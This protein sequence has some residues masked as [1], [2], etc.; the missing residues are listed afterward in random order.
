MEWI[1][2][3]TLNLF[4]P[5]HV[6]EPKTVEALAARWLSL[7]EA[8]A[9]AGFAHGDL[10]H[11]NILVHSDGLKLIDY[12]GLFVPALSGRPPDEVGHRNYQPP[13][14]QRSDF[15]PEM[16]RFSALLILTALYSL[17][18][19]PW[20]WEKHGNEENLLFSATDLAAPKKS[21]LFKVLEGSPNARLRDLSSSLSRATS[22]NVDHPT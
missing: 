6:T 15:G 8:M 9:K 5:N 13:W 4:L 1:E 2:A 12:D 22:S 3:P 17:V 20:L 14:R 11:G 21:A 19:H 7:N 16:D 18:D 10:Q